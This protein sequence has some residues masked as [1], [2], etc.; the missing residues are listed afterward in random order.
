M[1]QKAI[2]WFFPP[3]IPDITIINGT[4][5]F[6]FQTSGFLLFFVRNH[7]YKACFEFFNLLA[8]SV[9]CLCPNAPDPDTEADYHKLFQIYQLSPG[10]IYFRQVSFLHIVSRYLTKQFKL[11]SKP[12]SKKFMDKLGLPVIKQFREWIN[13]KHAP[14]KSQFFQLASTQMTPFQIWWDKSDT[15]AIVHCILSRIQSGKSFYLAQKVIKIIP[16]SKSV[17]LKLKL[18]ARQIFDIVKQLNY[19]NF[20]VSLPSSSFNK[21]QK[22]KFQIFHRL[23]SSE[24]SFDALWE[25]MNDPISSNKNTYQKQTSTSTMIATSHHPFSL[26]CFRNIGFITDNTLTRFDSFVLPRMFSSLDLFSTVHLNFH[27][28]TTSSSSSSL[29]D[30]DSE[31]QQ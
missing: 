5:G 16:V 13:T 19:S 3:T 2:L 9:F 24:T 31:C 20:S 10:V 25:K 14:S 18:V 7:L 21:S 28:S 17:Q 1:F 15:H 22:E 23:F 26:W 12:R 4:K 30:P 27:L 8:E 29:I 6:P 11:F